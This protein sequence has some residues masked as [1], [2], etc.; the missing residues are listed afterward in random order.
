MVFIVSSKVKFSM[1]WKCEYA[2][3]AKYIYESTSTAYINATSPIE[4]RKQNVL[5]REREK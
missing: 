1:G 3:A 2:T 4:W 5:L